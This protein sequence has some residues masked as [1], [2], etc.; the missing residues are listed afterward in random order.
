LGGGS[1]RCIAM[2]FGGAPNGAFCLR[3]EAAGCVQ[4]FEFLQSAVSLSGAPAEP[5]CSIPQGATSCQA[6]RA[7]LDGTPCTADLE[8]GDGLGGLCKKVGASN[9]C[10]IPCSNP[11]VCQAVHTCQFPDIGYCHQHPL[12]PQLGNLV[13]AGRRHDTPEFFLQTAAHARSAP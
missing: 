4:P 3:T 1:S 9:R 6:M 12:P 5:Y 7:Y 11:T 8:C 13:P 2:Q 10:T